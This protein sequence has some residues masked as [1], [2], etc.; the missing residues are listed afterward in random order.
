MRFSK[1][2]DSTKR[3]WEDMLQVLEERTG[4]RQ[5]ATVVVD[6][7]M[8][9][10]ENLKQIK[11]RGH[12][13]LV[14]SRQPERNQHLDEIEDAGEWEE[15]VREPSPRNPFQKKARVFVKRGDS[16]DELH[17]LCSSEGRR[18]KDRAIRERH[19]KR[20]LVDLKKLAQRIS[21]G[22]LVNKDK[23]HE[24][25]GRLK[26][27]YPRIARYYQITYDAEAA[28]LSWQ[29]DE[30][31]KRNAERLDGSYMLKTDRD[32]LTAEEIWRTYVL[33]T[34]V[35]SAFRSMKSPLMERPIFH[36]IEHR[37]QTHIFLCV[38]AYH[39][40]VSIEKQFLD[41]GIHTSWD[42][43]RQQL[44]TH[45]VVTVALP[46]SNGETLK[47]RKATTPEKIHKD[48][49]DTLRI[50]REVM[51]PQKTWCSTDSH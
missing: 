12:H 30:E 15:I 4:K 35:E 44:S 25:I 23:I 38:L 22:R 21:T 29:E 51:K 31:K 41:H 6:R 37:V 19:E 36:H 1:A 28:A 3:Q 46:A 27:R 48:I 20:L 39:L 45:Q 10:D 40:L 49:Y 34:R 32:D 43:L 2:I 26:E 5:G 47:I 13:Y 18:E 9:Y 16:T 7:G 24:S 8:A 14:A 50:P 42:T 33:L 11:A 17:I